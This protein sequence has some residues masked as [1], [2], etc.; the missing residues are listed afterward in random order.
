MSGQSESDYEQRA[1]CDTQKRPVSIL[2]LHPD[3]HLRA[4]MKS[5]LKNH[6][7]FQVLGVVDELASANRLAR[8]DH[9]D[10]AVVGPQPPW[11]I[12]MDV[13]DSG[14]TDSCAKSAPHIIVVSDTTDQ[15]SVNRMRQAGATGHL[16]AS[17]S[18]GE[19][20]VKAIAW[21]RRRGNYLSPATTEALIGDAVSLREANVLQLVCEGLSNRQIAQDL[22]ISHR[23]VESHR[24]KIRTKLGLTNTV[25]IVR[26]AI[27]TGLV[28]TL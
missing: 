6:H 17:E 15:E 10:I 8:N 7:E 21:V 16:L 20:L 4:Q 2:V 25:E 24:H 12:P 22:E 26:Y 3:L 23:T 18:S 1:A 14:C 5:V 19:E 28:S 11:G 13:P 27:R 9:P